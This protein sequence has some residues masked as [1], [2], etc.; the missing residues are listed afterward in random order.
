MKQLILLSSIF[1][2]IIIGCEKEPDEDE[3]VYNE[4]KLK[5]FYV[6]GDTSE[7][8]TYFHYNSAGLLTLFDG[9]PN[10]APITYNGNVV[11]IDW[12]GGQFYRYYL[13]PDS[14]ATS[15]ARWVGG[16]MADT[17]FYY[18]DALGFMTK[19]VSYNTS[20][21]KDSTIYTYMNNNLTLF[22]RFGNGWSESTS[23]SYTNIPSK[24]WFD[25]Y[26]VGRPVGYYFPWLGRRSQHLPASVTRMGNQ[27]ENY[28]YTM[29]ASGYISRYKYSS[30][31]FE[32]NY[33]L[34]Y[35]CQ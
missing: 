7:T 3:R 31:G 18:Y 28:S 4:C 34:D 12:G 20:F 33:R 32:V 27:P 13:G 30:A 35:D 21:G 5:A 10:A 29:N 23:A 9:P 2:I 25:A 26:L 15:S 22:Q 8:A 1:T 24:S 16:F 11:T 14:L 6:I 19:E 17:T